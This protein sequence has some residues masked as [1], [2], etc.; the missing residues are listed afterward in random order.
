[1]NERRFIDPASLPAIPDAEISSDDVE[2]MIDEVRAGVSLDA[3]RYANR[4][5]SFRA[6][7]DRLAVRYNEAPLEADIDDAPIGNNR[8]PGPDSGLER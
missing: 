4:S 8:E 5:E 6:L 1:M 2:Q 7:W 3:S